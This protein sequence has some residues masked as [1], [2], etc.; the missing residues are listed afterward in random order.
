MGVIRTV[1]VLVILAVAGASPALAQATTARPASR[2]PHRT[3]NKEDCLSC[4][5]QGNTHGISAVPAEHTYGNAA[6][7]RCHR[8]AATLPSRSQHPFDA[9]HTRCAACHAEG[10]TVNAQPIPATHGGYTAAQC[11]MCHEPQ[12]PG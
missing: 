6:C 5:R 11:V 8:P 10:N 12:G 1:A 3:L 7:V 4:H 9:A 2:T